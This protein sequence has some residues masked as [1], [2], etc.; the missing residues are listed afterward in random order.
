MM[1]LRNSWHV[2]RQASRGVTL[3]SHFI[4]DSGSSTHIIN[5]RRRFIKGT[6]TAEEG[7]IHI[8]DSRLYYHE[9]GW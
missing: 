2:R 6:I 5:D 9:K 1:Q 8:G 3:K 4:H 7:A